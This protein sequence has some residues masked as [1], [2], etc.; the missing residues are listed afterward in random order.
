MERNKRKRKAKKNAARRA[1][2]ARERA[3]TVAAMNAAA[4][5]N[6]TPVVGAEADVNG[7]A[8]EEAPPST[9]R[10]VRVPALRSP[11]PGGLVEEL[12]LLTA[13][14]ERPV[15]KDTQGVP[16]TPPAR[17][18]TVS[19]SMALM[20][21]AGIV[22]G[23]AFLAIPQATI[24]EGSPD[25]AAQ[26]QMH[27]PT[28]PPVL[29]TRVGYQ[30][31]ASEIRDIVEIKFD[32]V[33]EE[34][35]KPTEAIVVGETACCEECPSECP[36]P[37]TLSITLEESAPSPQKLPP[38]MIGEVIS[39]DERIEAARRGAFALRMSTPANLIRAA[40]Q[41]LRNKQAPAL[42]S[43]EEV[44]AARLALMNVTGQLDTSAL[45]TFRERLEAYLQ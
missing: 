31:T 14:T 11:P 13:E 3:A 20:I 10:S 40:K 43:P 4:A 22:G 8:E 29:A 28:A 24:G 32:N 18:K 27:A 26:N 21:F 23:A 2:K 1:K 45:P 39:E 44:D 6:A 19:L 38:K 25:L 33:T 30:L 7:A 42:T 36:T 15:S 35:L 5:R 12:K 37:I 9:L 34:F 17:K 41:R 16:T